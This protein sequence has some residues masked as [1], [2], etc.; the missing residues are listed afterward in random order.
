M[1]NDERIEVRTAAELEAWLAST[2][3]TDS[4]WLVTYKKHHPDYLSWDELVESLLAHGWIDSTARALDEDRSMVRIAPRRAGSTW[5]GRNKE[6]VARLE[7]SGRMTDAGRAVVDRA[8]ADGTWTILDDVEA[9]VVPD[10]LAAALAEAGD[11]RAHWDSFPAGVKKQLLWWVKSA[12]REAT[13]ERR[14][15]AIAEDAA[16]GRRANGT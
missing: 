11:A 14:I 12:R 5:S 3:R 10:D 9:L 16:E 15:A 4:I 13:R 6:A 8:K 7:A 1:P 2:D